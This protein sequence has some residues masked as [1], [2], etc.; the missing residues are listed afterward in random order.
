MYY[1]KIKIK[2]YIFN[3]MKNKPVK[4]SNFIL[5]SELL[6]YFRI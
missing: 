5:Q 2:L 3:K 6:C 4:E 1:L